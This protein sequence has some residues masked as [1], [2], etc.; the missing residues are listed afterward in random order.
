[1]T[2][3][4][5]SFS[6][7]L[8]YAV[9]CTFFQIAVNLQKIFPIL[10]TEKCPHISGPEKFKP[11]LFKGKLQSTCTNSLHL[12]NNLQSIHLTNK[13]MVLYN[14]PSKSDRKN[15]KPQPSERQ[16]LF[17]LTLGDW[18]P[19]LEVFLLVF[20]VFQLTHHIPERMK[21]TS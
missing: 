5:F 17:F 8:G 18:L 2:Y 9:V 1:M 7:F 4:T 19:I 14:F 12:L 10:H 3:L 21:R 20:P 13:T 16:C 11:V 15:S 6:R